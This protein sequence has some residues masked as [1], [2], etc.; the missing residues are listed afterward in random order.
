[1]HAHKIQT[2]PALVLLLAVTIS[3]GALSAEPLKFVAHRVGTCRSEACGV[4]DFNNDGKPDIV[5]GA[6]LY[7]APDW[8]ARK[9][10]T[11]KGEVDNAGKGYMWDFMNLPIDVDGDG[12]LDV[13]S[14]SWFEKLS[15]WHRNI[16]PA[17]GDWPRTVVEENGNFEAGDLVDID[18]DGKRL[19]ILPDVQE[20]RWYEIGT[21]ADGRRGLVIHTVSKRLCDFGGGAG[22]LN[23][24]G[25][26]DIIRPNAWYE[27]P[28][29]LRKG[30]WKEH[31]F[32]LGGEEEGKTDHTPQIL[33]YDVNADGLADIITSSAHKHGIFWYEQG[34]QAGQETW[35]RHV[36]DASWTQAHALSLADFDGDG[37]PE[38]VTGK[39]FM[40]H[41][42]S[43]PDEDKPPCI[44]I[45]DLKRG[46]EPVWT[47]HVVSQDE[48][49]GAGLSIPVADMDGDGD[50]DF[51]VTGKWGG[52]V[53]F[54]NKLK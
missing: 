13:V 9:I 42:G 39:R 26:P 10:R 7:M 3:A 44:Y 18:G 22:D 24:D 23:G 51:V 53:W 40:A 54:E 19:E 16:G 31:P 12:L 6:W 49:I 43:D 33:V 21:G 30:E 27:A 36:I 32:A 46:S 34:K 8:K 4:G 35:K 52:P 45:Y 11:L 1:M 17:P 37:V 2:Y 29:D 38:L 5:A 48:G 28:P 47:R 41:N 50:L 14:C 20:T 15:D 25:R